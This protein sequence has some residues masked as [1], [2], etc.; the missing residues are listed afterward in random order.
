MDLF[1]LLAGYES[2]Y[3]LYHVDFDDERRPR[4]ARL[5]ARWYSSF[6]KKNGSSIRVPRVQE[7]LRLTTIF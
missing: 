2:K 7:D 4:Q 1:E 3:G 6:L 5:S